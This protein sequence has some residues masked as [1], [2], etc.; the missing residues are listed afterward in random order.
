MRFVAGSSYA[1]GFEIKDFDGARYF[2]PEYAKHRPA[3][4]AFLENKYYEPLT[5]HLIVHLLKE[6]PGNLLH[7]GTF[8]GD[9]LPDFS[10][11][12]R[13]D[14][15]VYAFEP[16]LENYVLARLTVDHNHLDN[17]ALFN[18]ALGEQLAPCRISRGNNSGLHAGGASKVAQEGDLSSTMV[19][20]DSLNLTQLSILQ[21]DVEGHELPALRG[22]KQTITTHRPIIMLE[23]NDRNCGEFLGEAR[24]FRTAEIPGLDIWCP[25]EKPGVAGS[26]TAILNAGQ[27]QV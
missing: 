16:L 19:T 18:S 21:L 10:R 26:I 3:C 15:K 1:I 9:M 8:F 2:I 12:C 6:Y 11:A 27:K 23:D 17:V 5:H 4:R 24:Y 20:V 14:G 22:A 7:A 25:R 13:P